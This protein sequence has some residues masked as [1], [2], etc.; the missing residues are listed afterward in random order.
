MPTREHLFSPAPFAARRRQVFERLGDRALVLPSAPQ[1]RRS[2]DTEYPYRPDSELQWV[3]GIDEPAAV[4]VLRGHSDGNRFVL[5]VR[6]RDPDAELWTGPRPD[7]EAL[8][9][10]HGADAVYPITELAERLPRML[11]GSS[12]VAFRLGEGR[13]AEH[14]VVEALRSARLRG[15]RKGRGPRAIIDPGEILDEL[16]LRKS[17]DELERMRAAADLTVAAFHQVAPLMVAGAGEWQIQGRLDGAFRAGGGQGPAYESIVGS[18]PNACV[19]H[20]VANDRELAAGDLVLIDAGASVA[21]YAA[22]LSRTFPVDGRFR[23]ER[24]A[25]YEIV[26]A[27]RAQALAVVA[28]GARIADVHR[29]ATECITRGLVDL[30]VLG[31]DEASDPAAHHPYFPHQTSHW[32]GQDVHDVG[33]Y[34]VAGESRVLE[35][36]M[37]LTIEP[38]LYFSALA[39]G[40]ASGRADAFEGIGVRIEDDVVVTATGYENL[41]AAMPTDPDEIEAL[42]RG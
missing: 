21:H 34:Q 3:T 2:R 38:G 9:E 33:D 1:M 29:A 17:P 26:E 5:F 7:P 24:R 18:G 25:V 19:L 4:A 14:P 22:D 27:A 37:V 41:T 12:A 6:D 8:R 35:P 36:G 32:L 23:P 31:A 13:P 40:G 10:R 15:A 42:V 30:G 16:R 39:V 11:R 20:Y 28:P